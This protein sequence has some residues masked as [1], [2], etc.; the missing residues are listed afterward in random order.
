MP[1]ELALCIGEMIRRK[2]FT[3][4]Y[5]NERI[6]SFPYQHTDK[7]DKPHKIPQ[8]FTVKKSI[9]G[10][11]HENATLL[12][13]LSLIIGK[14]VPEEDGA[15]TV[16]LM[17]VVE[18]SLCSEFTEKSIQYLQSKIQDHREMLKEAFPDFKLCP[19]HHY[20]EHYPDLVGRFG[21]LVHLWTMRFEGKH[22][23]FKR[24]V[25]DTHNF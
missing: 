24:V 13:L 8:T 15:W 4:E 10:N 14:A 2:Y 1:V 7:L 9:G 22:R 18:L 17:E 21:P 23:F 5:L 19:K 11:G 6:L 16:L 3:L 12:R 25:H 20:I